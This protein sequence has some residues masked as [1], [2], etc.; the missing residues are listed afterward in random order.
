MPVYI[1]DRIRVDEGKEVKLCTL[2]KRYFLGEHFVIE[3]IEKKSALFY[4]TG[5]QSDKYVMVTVEMEEDTQY[6]K[7]SAKDMIKNFLYPHTP[8]GH[9]KSIGQ[10]VQCM[11][12]NQVAS[13]FSHQI[14]RP[15]SWI[16]NAFLTR[17]V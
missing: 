13:L 11:R 16:W 10:R 4:Y 12:I 14:L 7:H 3:H 5:F 17:R 2:P 6:V 15:S 8:A 9:E 1:L